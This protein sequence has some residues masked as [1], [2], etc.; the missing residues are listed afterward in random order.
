MKRILSLIVVLTVFAGCIKE[1]QTGADLKVGDELPD[2]EVVMSDGTVV[3][4]DIL[5]ETVSV[6]MFFHTSCPDCQQTL[7]QMQKIYDEFSSD[8]IN[9]ALIS[10]EEPKISIDAF[11]R[12]KGLKMPY[13]AQNDRTIYE[14]FAK[15]RIPRVYVCE[16]GGI[17]RYIFTDDPNP[18]YESIKISLESLIR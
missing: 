11:W 7:P 3:S 8:S 9:I 1:R 12:E 5:R 16:K 2:F 6:I 15:E 14:L 4:D 17:I 13:S 18:S 10:R